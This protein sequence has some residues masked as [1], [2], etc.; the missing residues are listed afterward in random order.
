MNLHTKNRN[1]LTD[2]ENIY[3]YQ[4]GKGGGGI[5]YEY[6]INRYKQLYIKWI[7]NKDALYNTGNIF[8]IL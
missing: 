7:R 6:E 4:R 8:S 2:I 3:G 1:R 5:N